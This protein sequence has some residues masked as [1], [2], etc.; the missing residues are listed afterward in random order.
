MKR[1]DY[2]HFRK[3]LDEFTGAQDSEDPKVYKRQQILKAATA[4][5]IHHGYRKTSISDVAARAQVAKGTVYL[6]FK[7]KPEILVHAIAEEKRQY[8]GL[9]KPILAPDKPARARLKEWV[10]MVLVVG[11][12]MPLT[13]KLLTGDPEFVTPTYEFMDAH[14]DEG[15]EEMQ[16]AFVSHMVSEALGDHCLTQDEIEDRAKVLLALAYFSTSIANE[17]IR[18]GLSLARFAALLSG[19]IVDGIGASKPL[20]EGLRREEV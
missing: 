14:K 3:I 4:L 11:S 2:E 13:S 20:E 8:I 12:E 6:Y 7:N 19:M 5:F 16:H 15:W 18:S 9:L 17:R 1:W 10:E